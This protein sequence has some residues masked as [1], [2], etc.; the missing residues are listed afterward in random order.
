MTDYNKKHDYDNQN[1]DFANANQGQNPESAFIPLGLS[2]DKQVRHNTLNTHDLRIRR[3]RKGILNGARLHQSQAA[4]A[5]QRH[6]PCMLTLTY[7][8]KQGSYWDYAHISRLM[9]TIAKY[10]KRHFGG[11]YRLRYVWVLENTKAGVPHYHILLWLPRGHT[12]PKPDK[13]GWWPHGSTRIERVKKAVG[14]MAKYASKGGIG[15]PKGARMHACGGLDRA[16][17]NERTWWASPAWVRA[18]WQA[19]EEPRP[20]SGGGWFSRITGEW[21]PSP[22]EVVARQGQVLIIRQRQQVQEV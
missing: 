1:P 4:Q 3:M 2:I 22:W 11:G 19:Q 5:N 6:Y 21:L 15:F 7:A 20:C 13:R 14:Y 18:V 12:L 16:G 10:A 8:W 17:R 9:D